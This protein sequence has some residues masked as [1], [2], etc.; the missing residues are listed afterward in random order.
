MEEQ[1]KEELVLFLPRGGGAKK[2]CRE[3]EVVEPKAM[4]EKLGRVAVYLEDDRVIEQLKLG[5][6]EEGDDWVIEQGILEED[7]VIE[8][9]ILEEGRV[10]VYLEDDWVIEQ[11][12]EQ[13]QEMVFARDGSS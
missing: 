11:E 1:V 2:I 7:W 10:A 5:R 8:Q 6:D 3:V 4:F 13:E 12:K 9:G